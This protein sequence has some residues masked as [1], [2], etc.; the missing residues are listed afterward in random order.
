MF[1]KIL[2]MLTGLTCSGIA[3][4]ELETRFDS[5]STPTTL[6]SSS[7]RLF[8]SRVT[9]LGVC[10]SEIRLWSCMLC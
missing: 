7:V 8:F 3:L 6:I 5:I 1:D 10:F 2:S 9:R 4:F